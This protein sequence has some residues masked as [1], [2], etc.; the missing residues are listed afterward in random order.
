M[1]ALSRVSSPLILPVLLYYPYFAGLLNCSDEFPSNLFWK[2][3]IT[4]ALFTL[5]LVL[6]AVGTSWQKKMC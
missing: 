6:K 4:T 3:W 5:K 1:F 2:K